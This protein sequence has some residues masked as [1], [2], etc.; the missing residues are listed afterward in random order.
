MT[1][2]NNPFRKIRIEF[3]RSSMAVKVIILVMLVASIAAMMALSNALLDARAQAQALQNQATSLEAENSDLSEKLENQG[4]V[5][6]YLEVAKE[7][8]G[9]VDPDTIIF[10]PVQ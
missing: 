7:E 2:P 4:S 6:G 3:V 9:L 8:L 1:K 10:E 5:E